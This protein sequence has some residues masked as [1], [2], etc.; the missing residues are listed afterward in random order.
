M[1]RENFFTRT[2]VPAKDIRIDSLCIAMLPCDN[3]CAEIGTFQCC[4]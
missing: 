4:C 2:K 1:S 3:F